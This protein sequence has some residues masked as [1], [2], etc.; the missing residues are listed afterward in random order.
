MKYLLCARKLVY[1]YKCIQNHSRNIQ[2]LIAMETDT[3]GHENIEATISEQNDKETAD[4]LRCNKAVSMQI[5][6]KNSRR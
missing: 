4:S 2:M 3:K 5:S 6:H 1:L